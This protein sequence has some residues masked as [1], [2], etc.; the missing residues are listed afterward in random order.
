MACCHLNRNGKFSIMKSN[1][2]CRIKYLCLFLVF[3]LSI[4]ACSKSGHN[5]ITPSQHIYL[6]DC[7]QK[8]WEDLFEDEQQVQFSFSN[9]KNQLLSISTLLLTSNG[10]YIVM[11]GSDKK[12]KLFDANGTFLKYI[13]KWGG[14]GPGE[15]QTPTNLVLDKTQELLIFDVFG[16]RLSRFTGKDYVYENEIHLK[17]NP[18]NII[19]D[20]QNNLITYSYSEYMLN[21]YDNKGHLLKKTFKPKNKTLQFFFTR[22]R[23]GGIADY[24][25]EGFFLI[26]PEEFNI[27]YY[28][29]DFNLK[30]V[31][32]SN[33][34]SKFRP[35]IS[36]LPEDLSPYVFTPKH[37]RWWDKELHI[38]SILSLGSD[39]IGVQLY[40]SEELSFT[41]FYLSLYKLNGVVLGEGLEIPHNGI[42]RYAKNGYLYVAVEAQLGTENEIIPPKLYRYKLREDVENVR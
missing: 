10:Q 24:Q 34:S 1:E 31:L 15:F 4:S 27:Y 7:K 19:V 13:G 21:K 39:I 33:F 30:L 28:D 29:Y 14:Q 35:E 41:D 32:Q 42:I 23:L 5:N 38:M 20:P 17:E 3:G 16:Y 11:D 18:S 22:F 9:T 26:Y 40:K 2:I 36:K 37:S 12:I 8:N 25:D 6:Q